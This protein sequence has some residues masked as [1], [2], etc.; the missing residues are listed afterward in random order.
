MIK[1]YC[2][3][4]KKAH[5]YLY[6]YVPFCLLAITNALLLIHLRQTT[7]YITNVNSTV[8]R[9]QMSINLTVILI[10][11]MF[12]VFTLPNAIVSH[13]RLLLWSMGSDGTAL[14]FGL[15]NLTLSYHAFNIVILLATNKLF[16]RQFKVLFSDKK[17]K[18]NSTSTTPGNAI[19]VKTMDTDKIKKIPKLPS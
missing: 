5:T 7:T 19:S 17:I 14:M 2:I 6:S 3:T 13:F 15:D 8:K 11:L 12:I 4:F 10:T 18:M 9:E 16:L 1:N